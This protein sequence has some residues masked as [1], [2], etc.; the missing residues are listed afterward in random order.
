MANQTLAGRSWI[1]MIFAFALTG[2][3]HS[4]LSERGQHIPSLVEL[5]DPP[6]G[7]PESFGVQWGRVNVLGVGVRF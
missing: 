3:Q 5:A 4:T 6:A 1:A 7:M 2:C